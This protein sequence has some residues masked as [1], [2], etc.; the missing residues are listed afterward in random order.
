VPLPDLGDATAETLRR[1]A[2]FPAANLVGIDFQ[3]TPHMAAAAWRIFTDPTPEDGWQ[4]DHQLVYLVR[5]W[6]VENADEDQLIDML[7]ADGFTGQNSIAIG[8]ASGQ[9]QTGAHDVKGRGSF[10]VFRRRG[11]RILPPDPRTKRNP[12]VEERFLVGNSLWCSSTGKRRAFVVRCPETE[13][14]LETLRKHEMRHGRP[15]K[16]ST[17]AHLSDAA[18][19]PLFWLFPRRAPSS[20]QVEMIRVERGRK[21]DAVG[22]GVPWGLRGLATEFFSPEEDDDE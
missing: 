9:Y 14:A 15:S 22:P 1:R 3:K 18:S 17:F 21:N 11:W 10:D 16:H 6:R 8:D 7:A 2:G 5:V 19:Y 13:A 20:G 12:P 4:H